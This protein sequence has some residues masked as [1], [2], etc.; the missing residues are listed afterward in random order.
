MKVAILTNNQSSFIQ[1]MAFGLKRMLARIGVEGQVFPLGL[2]MLDYSAFNRVQTGF[3]NMFKSTLSLTHGG[4]YQ[5]R[6]NVSWSEVK[7]FEGCLDK[8]D[9]IVVVSNIPDA[10]IAKRLNRIEK[11]RNKLTVPIVSYQNYYLGTRGRWSSLIKDTVNYGGGFGLERYDWY[12]SASMVS[13]Y[14][15]SKQPHPCSLIGH[16]LKDAN[17]FIPQGKRFKVLLDFNRKGFEAFR[18]LQIRALQETNTEYVQLTGRY[19]ISE[20]RRMYRDCGAF[21]TSFR[22]SFGLPLVENQLCGNYI[23]LPYRSWAPSHYINKSLFESGQGDLG[24][25]FIIY[26]NELCK[27]KALIRQCRENY[28]PEQNLANFQAEYPALYKGDLTQ[29]RAFVNKV[30][31]GAIT[32]QSHR[33]HGALN[34]G[35][36]Y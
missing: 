33:L 5:R 25:N 34:S 35:I 10:F 22:E 21:F 36:V 32:G 15:L 14:P 30:E 29:L 7:Q 1:P 2:A 23:F 17:L 6:Q 28:Y 9:L 20:I 26:D 31:V 13:E 18:Q 24:R 12:L 3:N 19:S 4:R 16:D 8:F 27:L 11:I